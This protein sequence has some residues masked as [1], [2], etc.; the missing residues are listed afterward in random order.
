MQQSAT[1]KTKYLLLAT[2][3]SLGT[4]IN[5]PAFDKIR[6][7]LIIV[8]EAHWGLTGK[9]LS[10]Y[11][12]QLDTMRSADPKPL[13]LLMTAT[14][15]NNSFSQFYRFLNLV[16]PKLTENALTTVLKS[17]HGRSLNAWL[18]LYYSVLLRRESEKKEYKSND[19][20]VHFHLVGPSLK[21]WVNLVLKTLYIRNPKNKL[22]GHDDNR[23]GREILFMALINHLRTWLA[24]PRAM[25]EAA[26]KGTLSGSIK[27]CFGEIFQD[28]LDDHPD[29]EMILPKDRFL[30]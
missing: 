20:F 23:K 6:A 16:L 3:N 24:C 26:D 21:L 14:P 17:R 5:Q 19:F 2:L 12:T 10:T 15:F 27:Q 4:R 25:L 29:T 13:L 18:T 8:D 11:R 30:R 7:C 9:N 28:H 22:L 1:K